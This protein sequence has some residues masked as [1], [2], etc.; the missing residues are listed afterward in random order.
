[1]AQSDPIKKKR[2]EKIF[3]PEITTIETETQI[4]L[5]FVFVFVFFFCSSLLIQIFH[6]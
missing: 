4:N 5:F 3:H 2:K 6:S 1:M